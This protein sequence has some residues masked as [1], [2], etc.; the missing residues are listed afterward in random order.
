MGYAAAKAPGLVH[1]DR[2]LSFHVD[3]LHRLLARR[4]SASVNEEKNKP[5]RHNAAQVR[6]L[7]PPLTCR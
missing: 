5:P 4:V 2:I 1:G 7:P 6:N 3:T